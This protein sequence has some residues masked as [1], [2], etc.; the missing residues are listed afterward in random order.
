MKKIIPFLFLLFSGFS[1]IAQDIKPEDLLAKSK[2]KRN[3][4]WILLGGGTAL[5][6]IG[7]AAGGSERNTLE[8]SFKGLVP[9]TIGLASGLASIPFFIR[10]GQLKRKANAMAFAGLQHIEYAGT[11]SITQ[12][13]AGIRISL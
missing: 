12:S 3:T 4:G 10:A 8:Q 9:A 2:R 6:V 5:V 1:V 7:A 13:V 11:G